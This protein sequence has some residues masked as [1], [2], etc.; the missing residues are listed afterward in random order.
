M[1]KEPAIGLESGIL[2]GPMTGIAN[3]T[4][5][6]V[7]SLLEQD[8]SFRYVGFE[9][10]AWRDISLASLHEVEVSHQ[11]RDASNAP[12][13]R[14]SGLAR[15][16]ATGVA[17]R[18]ARAPSARSLYRTI[19]RWRFAAS[20]RSQR[21]D[22]FHAF[23]YRPPSDP[24]VPMLPVV[25]DLST[26]RHPE[27]HPADRVRW[28]SQLG[29]LIDRA[30]VV[31]TI[32]EFSKREI[33][34]I[35]GT[36]AN[37]IFVAPPAAA[38]LYAQLGYDVTQ[39]D[40]ALLGLTYGNFFLTVGT[41]EPRKNIRTL[42]TA[43]AQ[44]SP[45]ERAGCPLVI[46]GGRGWGNLDL[47]AQVESLRREGTLCFLEGISNPQ[48][49][50]LYEGA[51]LLLMPS[52]YEGFGMP[53]V[54]ALACGAPVAFSADTAMDEISA[55]LGHRISAMDVDGW[56][57]ALRDALDR[58]DHADEAQREARIR[59]ARQFDWRKSAGLVSAAY[60]HLIPR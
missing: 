39:P 30:P 22:L 34:S 12:D 57:G 6:I 49:R 11:E 4:F 56:T 14:V 43:Y 9:R 40:L 8:G 5:H 27:F 16:A 48:L 41:L 42:I 23:N 19:L 2:L 54:E 7:R 32:S 46:A 10:L 53:V 25:Y 47:P 44:L 60:G 28:L 31:Q 51:R 1:Q 58:D 18:L 26:F 15:Q 24:G 20:V 21:L 45:A 13:K 36:P 50:S 29:G 35:F 55:G 38:P 37:K 33:I 59:Q 17:K 3:Y 52:L